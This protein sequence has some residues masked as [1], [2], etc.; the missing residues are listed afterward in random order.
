MI[1]KKHALSRLLIT[2]LGSMVGLGA[3]SAVDA[4]RKPN[5]IL[6]Y[7]DDLGIG[8][9]GCYG[10]KIVT[11]PNIDRL[12]AEGMKFNNY[13]G[14]VFC[15]PSRWSLST[16]MHDGR[17]GGWKHNAPGLLIRLDKKNTPPEKATELLNQYVEKSSAPIPKKEVFMAQIPQKA[18]YKTA[19]FGKLDVGFLTNHDRVKRF[20][21]DFYEGYYSHGRCHGFYPPYLW[22]N[23][24]RF[25]LEGN[26]RAD[27]GKMSEKGNEPVGD[28]GETY[29][30]N[31]FI[32]GILKYIRD[33]KNEPFFLYHSTQLPHGPVAIPELHP[34]YADNDKLS[35]AEKKYASMVKMLDDHVG[36]IMKEL[37]AQGLDENTIVAFTSDNGHEM[38]YGP[39]QNVHK[40]LA[41][42]EKANLTDNKWRTSNGGDV[43]D[44]AGGRAGIKRSGYQGGMQCPMIVRWPGKIAPGSETDI[45]SAHYDFMATLADI[46]GT[47]MP[48]GKDSISYLPTLLGKK[49]TKQHNYVIVN[50]GFDRMG[51]S[52]LISQ[53]G[54]KVVELDRKKDAFQLYNI[55][56]DNEE[57]D[58]LSAQ[59]PEKLSS[60]KKQLVSEL[61]SKRPDLK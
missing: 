61:N 10:Q 50:N 21:W 26:T 46:T 47:R 27:C 12:A 56:K 59:H 15:A 29:S 54:W 20:G 30:Q 32:E 33:H 25:E 14:G 49:Q 23:G 51:R 53:D 6:I 39:K 58:E 24:E 35:L 40:Q 3:L 42:G 36:L 11:T 5:V 52:A 8:M 31:V 48:R 22:R 2:A 57:R 7:A 44:G 18:G 13:Y 60:L 41:N 16:G 45:L 19:Q 17:L 4:A 37:K 9:L 34:D 1:L 28:G 38:Y 55:K 43:F